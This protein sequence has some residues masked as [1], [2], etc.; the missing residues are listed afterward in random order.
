VGGERALV[1]SEAGA[2]V[3]FTLGP[4]ARR[5]SPVARVTRL[6]AALAPELVA[7]RWGVQ[8]HGATVAA[9]DAPVEAGASCVGEVDA[10]V[11]DRDGVGLVVWG[12]DCV[13]VLLGSGRA[14]GA[15]HAGWRGA[16]AGVVPATVRALTHRYGV[17]PHELSAWLGPSIGACHYPVGPEVI[18]ALAATG[19]AE[20]HWRRD[21]RV[22]LRGFLRAELERAG[23]R[24]VESVGGCTACEPGLASYRRDGRHAGRQLAMV[25]RDGRLPAPVD[26]GT[27]RV[28]VPTMAA[29]R[30]G[31]GREPG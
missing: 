23:V 26:G 2:R 16:A 1:A 13:T 19:I 27:A 3:L 30:V 10:L 25:M 9:V 17:E 11:T 24:G 18:A 22:D 21:D 8:V 14:V 7:A 20:E 12:A 6:I 28:A 15:A 29:F 5:A 31:R 4:P